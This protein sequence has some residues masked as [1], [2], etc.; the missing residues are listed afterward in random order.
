MSLMSA[1]GYEIRPQSGLRRRFVELAAN[2]TMSDLIAKSAMPL[3]RLVLRGTRGRVTATRLLTGFPVL[4]LTTTGARSRQPRDVPLL[5]IPTPAKNLAVLGTNFGGD[6]TPAWV[7]NLLADPRAVARW[8]D[9][10]AHV[11][12]LQIEQDE[13]EP[14]WEAALAA[15]PNYANS[16][17][18]ASHRTIRVFELVR[19]DL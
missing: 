16:R 2:E 5:G 19:G 1:L 4:W 14:I 10:A 9:N 11:A 15:Y 18:G 17:A 3:D 13:Q 7:H 8:R 12:A 6:R